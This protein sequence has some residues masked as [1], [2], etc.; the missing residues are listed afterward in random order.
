[1]DT[2]LHILVDVSILAFFG[3]LY[4]FYQKRRI[5]RI[6][7]EDIVENLDS[8]RFKLNEYTESKS[9][10]SDYS[11]IQSFNNKFEELYQSQ[12][13]LELLKLQKNSDTLNKDLQDFFNL[14][15]KQIHDHLGAK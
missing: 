10:S 14:I 5:I 9:N 6:S 15:C 1:V 13:L 7:L 12:S 11:L 2:W 8:F 4:Y 3:I